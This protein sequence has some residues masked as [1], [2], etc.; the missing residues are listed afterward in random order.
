LSV[1]RS[2]F[3]VQRSAAPN[4]LAEL[5]CPVLQLRVCQ[6]ELRESRRWLRLIQRAPL[7]EK[8]E[9]LKELSAEA[10]ELV[11][12]FASSIPTAEANRV[13]KVTP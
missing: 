2:E 7:V 13:P 6:K 8:P 4:K 10:E 11:R 3:G 12:I 1:Q 5:D 9:L